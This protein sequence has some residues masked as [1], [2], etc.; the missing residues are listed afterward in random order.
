M[1]VRLPVLPLGK[2]AQYLCSFSCGKIAVQRLSVIGEG[3]NLD[4]CLTAA[5]KRCDRCT[6]NMGI[7][8]L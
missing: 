6:K 8:A 7:P 5:C 2:L 1:N 4:V 3:F